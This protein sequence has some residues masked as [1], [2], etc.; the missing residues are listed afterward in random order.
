MEKEDIEKLIIEK[1]NCTIKG[2]LPNDIEITIL[3]DNLPV[4]KMESP[5]GMAN[6]PKESKIEIRDDR[7]NIDADKSGLTL[8]N[9]DKTIPGKAMGRERNRLPIF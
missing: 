9:R 5:H 7:G 8:K 2:G 4:Q 6:I 1:Y 3:V